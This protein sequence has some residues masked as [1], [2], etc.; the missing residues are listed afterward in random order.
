[1]LNSQKGFA[2][3][4]A[5]LLILVITV[6]I[7]LGSHNIKNYTNLSSKASEMFSG[8]CDPVETPIVCENLKPGNPSSEWDIGDP[9]AD[10]GKAGFSNIQGFASN[11]SSNEDSVINFKVKTDAT[12]YRLDIY[13]LG[14]YGG[15]GARKI[16]TVRP[17]VSLPQIQ[18]DCLTEGTTGLVDCGN[19]ETSII[20]QPPLDLVSGV[21]IAKL[22]REDN[23]KGFSHIYFVIR[24]DNG[25]SDI[26]FQTSDTTWQAY[27]NYGGASLYENTRFTLPYGR[28]VK[29]SYNRP[30]NTRLET[31]PSGM[32]SFL[33]HNEYPMIRWLESNG[34]D[35]SYFAGVDSAS[36]GSE[37]LKHKA[38]ISV[39]H[40]EYWSGEQRA[41]VEAARNNGVNLAFFSGN[42]VF[43]KS[44]WEKSIDSA[45]SDFK[46]LVVYKE[47]HSG[48]KVDPSALWTGTWRD[49]RFSPPADGGK[50]ENNL[51]GTIFMVN[52][53]KS[54]DLEI[55]SEYS[56]MR[57]WRNTPI[58]NLASGQK[59][60]IPSMIGHEWDADL[61]NGFRPVGLVNYSLTSYQ[62]DNRYLVD[63]GSLYGDGVVSHALTLYKHPSGALVF[64]T[65]TV[66]WPWGLDG[67]H[68]QNTV[69][70][71]DD[72]IG[73]VTVNIFADMGIQP[74]TLKV[75]LI[76][77]EQSIDTTSP[78]STITT[79]SPISINA[80][81][82]VTISGTA[83][84]T[85]GVIGGVEVSVDNGFTWHKGKGK[86][87]WSYSYIPKTAGTVDIKV[88]AVDDSG[89]VEV[90][91]PGVG[92]IV[93]FVC[94]CSIFNDSQSPQVNVGA[95]GSPLEVGMKVRTKVDG[96]ITGIRFYKDSKNTGTH[97]GSVWSSTGS[98]LGQAT[99]TNETA[100]GWQKANLAAAVP[101]KANT[102]YVV[103]YFS[104]SGAYSTTDGFFLSDKISGGLTA[105]ANNVD[106]GNGVYKYGSS[107]FPIN[108]NQATNYW[109]DA[110]FV[111]KCNCT[112]IWNSTDKPANVNVDGGA[113]LE[114]GVK[115]RSSSNGFIRGI[116]FYKGDKNTGTH[117]ASLWN[118]T[119]TKLG[120]INFANETA[121]GWQE[122]IFPNP[123][124]I[125]ANITYVASYHTN[126][127]FSSTDGFFANAKTNGVLTALSNNTGGGN[128]VYAYGNGSIFPSSPNQ[129]TNY[130]VDVLF[131][132]N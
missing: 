22:V 105:L 40:D 83:Q 54:E 10:L 101:I 116:R 76:A 73:Q 45:K 67:N 50:P 87:Q 19:W 79:S 59:A 119:G 21:Y 7:F 100:F 52:A 126:K 98:L 49:P 104:P 74:K 99:F 20:W 113:S 53:G 5:V 27:N 46:T 78:V 60:V 35:V 48:S 68:D 42:E 56:K 106:G 128:G 115:F 94:P 32:M 132:K 29:V 12:S 14:Y 103:S 108:S 118:S 86:E 9:D 11:F 2:H 89:N 90:P 58:A 131:S 70:K 124:A 23:I 114:V 107:G 97:V 57:L 16:E 8:S 117:T 72:R 109:V 34:Y 80:N 110:E 91:K 39:G 62:I 127:Y 65:G 96:Y 61:D 123:I 47:T 63:N 84:D 41:N 81:S 55:T 125:T 66:V 3:I 44:R 37:I 92:F 18:P 51:T 38:F 112:T 75:G 102:T 122:A 17:L 28:A 130:W 64:G 93:K 71:P 111:E 129:A 25:N 88:R 121:L 13:R 69:V 26:L 85:V 77:S 15:M 120:S 33:F 24:D 43:W 30:L 36:K 82:P 95:G 6:G 1:M 4:F 31:Y